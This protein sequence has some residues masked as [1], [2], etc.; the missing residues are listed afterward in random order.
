MVAAVVKDR[1]TESN[2]ESRYPARTSANRIKTINAVP[3]N[4]WPIFA[5]FK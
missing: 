3:A 5:A 2:L 4:R 1:K